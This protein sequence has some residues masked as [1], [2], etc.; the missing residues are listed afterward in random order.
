MKFPK[1]GSGPAEEPTFEEVFGMSKE[2]FD[3]KM[4]GA[5]ADRAKVTELETK[6]AGIDDLRTQLE[7]LKAKPAPQQGERPAPTNFFEDP[8]KAFGERLAPLAAVALQTQAGLAEMNARNRFGKDFTRW[9]EEI[10]TLAASHTNLADKG[11]PQ[12]WENIVNMIRGRHAGEIEESAAKGQFYFTEQPG[13]AGGGGSSESPE[14]KLSDA[15]LKAAKAFGMTAKEFLDGQAYV[16]SNYS[17]KGAAIV[18]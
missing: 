14:S 18:H 9:G 7:A 2:A 1:F 13:G 3:A 12:F 15:E 6:V 11:N 5:D 17:H 8:D 10:N 4:A 16:A